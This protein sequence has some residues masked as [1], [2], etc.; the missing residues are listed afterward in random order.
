MQILKHINEISAVSQTRRP[1]SCRI[2]QALHV[3]GVAIHDDAAREAAERAAAA[4]RQAEQAAGGSDAGPRLS[5]KEEKRQRRAERAAK[6]AHAARDGLPNGV[7]GELQVC[8]DMQP[9]HV[10]FR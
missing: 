4:S 10:P 8:T 1:T 2:L 7:S 5:R 3:A 9:L 6:L